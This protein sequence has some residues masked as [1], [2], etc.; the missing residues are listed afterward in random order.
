MLLR[1]GLLLKRLWLVAVLAYAFLRA[2]AVAYFLREYGVDPRIYL[3]VDLVTSIPF[4]ICSGNLVA[5]VAL[6]KGGWFSSALITA[7]SYLAPDIYLMSAINQAPSQIYLLT[8][9]V[10]ASLA[11]T[12]VWLLLRR[13]KGQRIS[14]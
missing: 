10:I 3:G 12:S 6:G 13:A 14:H 8:L 9:L 1:R 4:G 2:G 7:V 11:T 5:L